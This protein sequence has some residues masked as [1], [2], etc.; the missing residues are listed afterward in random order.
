[1]LKSAV[2]E[3]SIP[4]PK[5]SPALHTSQ[6]PATGANG[7]EILIE[8]Q[9]VVANVAQ[10]LPTDL[11]VLDHSQKKLLVHSANE[12]YLGTLTLRVTYKFQDYLDGEQ[13][14]SDFNLEVKPALEDA[15]AVKYRPVLYFNMT[16]VEVVYKVTVGQAWSF[17]VPSVYYSDG[18]EVETKTATL[19]NLGGAK[20]FLDFDS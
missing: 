17:D 13:L 11:A 1:M 15:N 10:K 4:T 16:N 8:V 18:Q 12:A 19:S 3:V 7:A 6:N 5:M 14:A 2:L 20:F 9:L